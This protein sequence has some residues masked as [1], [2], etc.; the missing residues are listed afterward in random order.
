MDGEDKKEKL[1]KTTNIYR[2]A[3]IK[4]N[5]GTLSERITCHS[6]GF[7]AEMETIV[8]EKYILKHYMFQSV[9]VS[10]GP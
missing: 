10:S 7:Y 9:T 4:M 3:K 8:V 5:S 1:L 6:L 2:G